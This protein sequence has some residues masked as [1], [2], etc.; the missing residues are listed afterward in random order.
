MKA[1]D[2]FLVNSFEKRYAE[3]PGNQN[4]RIAKLRRDGIRFFRETGLPTK[5]I[6]Q[7]RDYPIDQRLE[8]EYQF[9]LSPDPYRPIKEIFRCKIH[10]IDTNMF[11]LLNGWY[12]H[13]NNPFTVMPNG[14]MIGSI[15]SAMERY[16]DLVFPCL[17]KQKMDKNNS[18][19]ALNQAFFNDGLFIYIPDFLTVEQPVQL[20]N[21]IETHQK[22]WVQNRNLIILGKGASLSF[23]HC[24]DSIQREKSFINNVTEI[25]LEEGALLNYCKMENKDADSLLIDHV[26]VHQKAHSKMISNAIT[27]NAGYVRNMFHV[28]L[29]E[30]HAEVRLNGLYLVDKKQVVDNHVFVN[31]AAPDCNSSQ[32]YKGILDD[33]AFAHFNGHILV[34]EDSQRTT[35]LQTNKNITLTDEA[36]IT[37]KPFLEIYAD[38]VQCSHGAT[39]GQLDEEAM[40]YLRSR[41][42]CERNARMLLMYAFA[43][44]VISYVNIINLK[45]QLNELIQRRLRGELT[46]CDRCVLHCSDRKE[47]SFEIDISKI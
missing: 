30:P 43:N 11:S 21:L 31:H 42:I 22:L 41:G 46:L 5:K 40:F 36:R 23:V 12:L 8:G 34:A 10:D 32:L 37:T 20:V 15:F 4:E 28:N 9:Q 39:V 35:A 47:L 45:K 2:N 24:N 25:F 27:F 16:P 17:A 14:M 26:T 7:W 44:E 6:E 1:I 38:D 18:L 33:E 29:N 19:I 13:A 3:L